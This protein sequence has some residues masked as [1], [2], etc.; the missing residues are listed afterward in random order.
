MKI[1]IILFIALFLISGCETEEP[2]FLPNTTT[3]QTQDNETEINETEPNATETNETESTASCLDTDGGKIY[4]EKG[5]TVVSN[6]KLRQVKDY[7]DDTGTLIEYYCKDD[8]SLGIDI[9]E[10][11]SVGDV[12]SNGACG[13]LNTTNTTNST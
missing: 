6:G 11:F 13:E 5:T 9:Y 12:C 3:N 2:Y 7:C 10:C 1:L 8:N 4:S